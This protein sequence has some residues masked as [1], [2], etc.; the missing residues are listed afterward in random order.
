ME[1]LL[2]APPPYGG[3]RSR[4]AETPPLL[5]RSTGGARRSRGARPRRGSLAP[6]GAG[7]LGLDRH[8]LGGGGGGLPGGVVEGGQLRGAL[9][10][11]GLVG[12]GVAAVDGLGLVAD[13]G[14]GGGPRDA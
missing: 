3:W 11:H 6:P 5:R 8:H 14:H 4:G 13:H 1:L 9:T 12:D 2:P 7:R 10:E